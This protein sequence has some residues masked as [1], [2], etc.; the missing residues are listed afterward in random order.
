M[1]ILNKFESVPLHEMCPVAV[2]SVYTLV[3]TEATR[4]TQ[5]REMHEYRA[6]LYV[7][8]SANRGDFH[9]ALKNAK[10]QVIDCLY[11]EVLSALQSIETEVYA[12]DM[13]SAI[14]M[15]NNLKSKIREMA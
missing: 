5:F 14:L 1:T 6:K 15:I 13:K 4:A 10:H 12:G 3:S 2:G 7:R 11:G 8:F 9:Y